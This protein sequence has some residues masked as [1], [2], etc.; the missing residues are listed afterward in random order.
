MPADCQSVRKKK[1][2]KIFILDFSVNNCWTTT[3]IWYWTWTEFTPQSP[4]EKKNKYTFP[5][6]ARN[7]FQKCSLRKIVHVSAISNSI[8]FWRRIL[9]TKTIDFFFK[10]TFFYWTQ[11]KT[12]WLL[13]TF[14]IIYHKGKFQHIS[15]S[16]ESNFPNQKP[17]V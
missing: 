14:N 6:L 4:F 17:G 8:F 13:C 5:I 7:F 12:F 9:A 16:I 11:E 3:C 2:P 15:T 10:V 1:I